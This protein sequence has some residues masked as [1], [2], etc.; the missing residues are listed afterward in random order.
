MTE[1]AS[2]PQRT[3][4]PPPALWLAASSLALA[5]S[6]PFPAMAADT[7][8]EATGAEATETAALAALTLDAAD[9]AEVV[10]TARRRDE[11]AQDVPIALSVVSNETLANIGNFSVAQVQQVVPTLQVFSFNPRNTNV[12]IRGLGSNIS[13]TNDGLDNGVGIY[14]DN[15]FYGRVGQSQFDLVDLQQIEVLRGPQGTLFGKNTTAG[16][17]NISTRAPSFEPEFSGE[18]TAGNYGAHQARFSASGPLV[19]DRLAVRLS[20]ADT[21]RDGFVRNMFNGRRANDN[22]NFSTRLQ[23]LAQPADALKIRLIGDYAKQTAH[24]VL[25]FITGVTTTYADGTPIPNSFI[26]RITRAGYTVPSFDPFDR[27]VSADSPYQANMESYGASGQID[28]ET[29]NHVLTSIT[30]WRAWDWNPGNDLDMVSLPVLT[31]ANQANRQRQF[32]QEI[33]LASA[34][35]RAVDYVVGAYYFWQTIRGYGL[36]GYGPAAAD[37]NL[38]TVPAFI[39]NAALSGFES[40]TYSEPTTNSY[41]LFGQATWNIN[42]SLSLTGGLRYTHETKKGAFSSWHQGGQDLSLLPAAAAGAA[43]GIRELFAPR[44]SYTAELSDDSVSGLLTLSYKVREGALVYASYSRGN[45]SGGL[46]LTLLPADVDPKVDPETVDAFEV[47]LKSQWFDE[48]VTLNLAAFHT[49]VSD[50]QTV[51]V[52]FV[53]GT[54]VFR[55]YVDNIPSVRSRGIEADIG[56]AVSERLSLSASAAYVDA[57]YKEYANAQ[58]APEFLNVSPT[59]DLSG[60]RLAGVPKFT[61]SVTADYTQPLGTWRGQA[62]E[63]YAHADYAHRSSYFSSITNSPSSKAGDF[64]LLNAR[65][66]LRAGEDG[67]WDLSVWARN[68]TDEKYFVT[69]GLANTGLASGLLG[70]PRTYGVTLRTK[71]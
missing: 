51:V 29:G 33:R 20:V 25:Q 39:G 49:K 59:Q 18:L 54:S 46:N 31:A 64:G 11:S 52:S 53:E 22:D 10:V 28:W 47:G 30:A 34:G 16:A 58:Q 12:N 2:S 27:K 56:W 42:D 36:T 32:S 24:G 40:R 26:D 63:L 68:L 8:A 6:L 57:I 48:A 3:R 5:A 14:I 65:L 17:I 43:Q 35:G 66:G 61:W 7:D 13:T 55:T 23:L 50:Y 45:K 44:G 9:A 67:R 60:E 19:E 69:T 1:H 38:P 71:L 37:W 4:V 70:D 62:L 41:A 21:H 15:V